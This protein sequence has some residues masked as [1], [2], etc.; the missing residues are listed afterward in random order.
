MLSD[1]YDKLAA[2]PT[3]EEPTYTPRVEFDG[4]KGFIDTG[5]IRGD[6]PT[7]LTPVFRECLQAA[8]YDP[9]RI[10]IGQKLRESHWQQRAR[11][12]TWSEAEERY[13]TSSEFETVWLHAYKFETFLI[14]TP[15]APELADIVKSARVER[16][17]ATGPHWFVFQAGDLQLGKRSSG[18]STEEIITRF[19]QSLDIARDELVALKR[20]GI[21]G[22]QVCFPG[23]CIE[24]NM[25]QSQRNLWLTQE[26]ITEQ[27]LM[28]Q[29]LLMMTVEAFAPLGEQLMLDVVNGNHDEAQRTQNTYPGNGWATTAAT[30]VDDALKLNPLAYNHVT[31]RVPPKWQGYMTVPV[32][33]TIV[34][35]AHGHQWR[36]D[37]A[38]QW[39]SEQALGNHAAGGSQILQCGHYHEFQIRSNADRTV[40]MSPT[41]DC[42]SDWYRE[43]RGSTSKRGGLAYLLHAGEISRMSVV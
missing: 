22:I 36:R 1:D 38:M 42:G 9:D 32:G 34:T 5:T 3:P 11:V 4:A 13:V 16:R 30:L 19:V 25:S 20:H 26:T 28:F 8:G 43:R 2:Q 39:W 12:R 23:D 10:R 21:E 15:Q 24:G 31:V 27:V 18:G 40:I 37:K 7:D 17:A 14:D 41:Y 29:R 33:D 35:V 6:V